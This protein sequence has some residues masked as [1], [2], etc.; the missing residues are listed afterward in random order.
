VDHTSRPTGAAELWRRGGDDDV[1]TREAQ[2]SRYEW[3]KEGRMIPLFYPPKQDVKLMLGELRDTLQSRWW[4]QGPKADRFEKEFGQR[5]GH[6]YCAFVNSGTAAL[7]LA[8]SLAGVGPQDE[9]IVPVL[10]CTATCHPILL[11]GAKPVFADIRPDTLTMDPS[12][13]EKKISNETKAIVVVHFGGLVEDV[14]RFRALSRKYNIPIIEDAA[15][16]LGARTLGYGDYTCFSFQ[17]IKHLTTGDGGMLVLR[18]ASEYAR[19]KRLRWFDI[20]REAKK[21]RKWQAWDR[22]G[23]TFDQEVPGYKYQ[24]NDIAASLGLA[25]LKTVRRTIEHRRKLAAEYR[26]LLAECHAVELLKDG[27]TANWLFM[28]KVKGDRNHFAE[29]LLKQGVETNVAHIRNDVFKVFGGKRL[30][31]AGM[32]EVE[33]QY[34]CLPLNDWVTID[35]V[36]YICNQVMS[37]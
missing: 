33:Q 4:G 6:K 10:T 20:D 3:L 30:N 25:G 9:V 5:F 28:V 21:N 15:Q 11:L 17:A 37:V 29:Y 13:V 23:I 35:D 34:I 14:K 31:L 26:K 1:S 19:A 12:D 32:H 36:R 24:G 16:A 18:K 27:D 7:H 22:R 2:E 8:Y